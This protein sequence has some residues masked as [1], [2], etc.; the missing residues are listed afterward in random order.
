VAAA[1]AVRFPQTDAV[2]APVA[3][4]QR[5]CGDDLT[6][7]RSIVTSRQVS[8]RRADATRAGADHG[9]RFGGI[10]GH[11]DHQPRI[12][13]HAVGIIPNAV[14]NGRFSALRPDGG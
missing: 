6:M 14:P 8:S 10:D 4:G 1:S 7:P 9:A 11:W 13:H 2:Q 3:V 12:V 5:P